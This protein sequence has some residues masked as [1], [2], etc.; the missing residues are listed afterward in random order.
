MGIIGEGK[1]RNGP[2]RR[3]WNSDW[4]APVPTARVCLDD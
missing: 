4:L 1:L 3:A 2:L